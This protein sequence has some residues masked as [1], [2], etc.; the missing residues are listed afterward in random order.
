MRIASS[1][2]GKDEVV[3]EGAMQIAKH[4]AKVNAD[5]RVCCQA[6]VMVKRDRGMQITGCAEKS[7]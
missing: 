5:S 3:G 6:K 2:A 1:A 4:T 7:R